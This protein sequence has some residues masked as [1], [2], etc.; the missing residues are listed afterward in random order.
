MSL[1]IYYEHNLYNLEFFLL[2]IDF[3]YFIM[4]FCLKIKILVIMKIKILMK[5]HQIFIRYLL[6]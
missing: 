2:K 4:I 1:N 3:Y 6:L 5:N